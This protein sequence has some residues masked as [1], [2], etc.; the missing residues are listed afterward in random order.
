MT[1]EPLYSRCG[2]C[3]G[4]GVWAPPA[5]SG[6]FF[7]MSVMPGACPDCEG[8]GHVATE[9]GQ[10]ILDLV[11]LWKSHGRLSSIRLASRFQ[12]LWFDKLRPN[13]GA[14]RLQS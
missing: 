10:R 13:G 2:K 8:V 12:R 11:R 1:Q 5:T 3:G 7:T 9:E 6:Q 4:S 14:F